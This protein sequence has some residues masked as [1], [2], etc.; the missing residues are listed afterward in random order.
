[1]YS[2]NTMNYV[3]V[4]TQG[5]GLE[6][7]CL[8]RR[9]TPLR[10]KI[11][12]KDRTIFLG[13]FQFHFRLIKCKKAAHARIS[14]DEVCVWRMKRERGKFGWS[15]PRFELSW[16][17][18]GISSFR[19]DGFFFSSYEWCRLQRSE[20]N[21]PRTWEASGSVVEDMYQR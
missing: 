10:I 15:H 4:W 2:Y 17:T 11:E 18:K 21:S 14:I 7:A 9:D 20:K 1:M 16:I 19:R 6:K 3:V 5:K 12:G 13:Q 8:Q